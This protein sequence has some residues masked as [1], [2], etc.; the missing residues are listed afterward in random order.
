MRAWK[1]AVSAV[2]AALALGATW[3]CAA[4]SGVDGDYREHQPEAGVSDAAV[5]SECSADPAACPD[6]EVREHG[7]FSTCTAPG[8]QISML[9]PGACKSFPLKQ[10]VKVE[11]SDW[12]AGAGACIPSTQ[13]EIPTPSWGVTARACAPANQKGT[14]ESGRAC[15]PPPPAG[16]RLC[17]FRSA[18]HACPSGYDKRLLHGDYTDG[19]G[20]EACT[21]GSPT[22]VCGGSVTLYSDSSCTT[23]IGAG[24]F[25]ECLGP[26]SQVRSARYQP[27]ADD[28]ACAPSEGAVTG[29]VTLEDPVTFCCL[30]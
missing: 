5:E 27:S 11:P 1:T 16:S 8:A 23:A 20:C 29:S 4:V 3:A 2:L 12:I 22:G 14:C 30:P 24:E 10:N 28:V 6:V 15:V 17:I 25:E 21:C 13:A 26:F 18:D 19:R 9:T 7:E